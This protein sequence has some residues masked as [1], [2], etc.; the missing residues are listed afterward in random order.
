MRS[1]APIQLDGLS[2]CRTLVI[3]TAA[4]TSPHLAVLLRVFAIKLD[5]NSFAASA[6]YCGCAVESPSG[7]AAATAGVSLSNRLAFSVGEF[8]DLL[9]NTG[10]PSLNSAVGAGA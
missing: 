5:Q 9:P 8:V 3:H 4:F 6:I 1:S 2:P 7:S 10:L